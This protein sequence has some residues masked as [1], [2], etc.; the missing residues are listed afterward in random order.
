MLFF[1]MLSIL[2]GFL[3]IVFVPFYYK[4]LKNVRKVGE[5]VFVNNSLLCLILIIVHKIFKK[6]FIAIT[7]PLNNRVHIV[8]L[9]YFQEITED[10]LLYRHEYVHVLQ[11]RKYNRFIFLIKYLFYSIRYGYIKNPLEVEAYTL[12]SLSIEEIKKHF[13]K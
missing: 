13:G 4:K 8:S 9:T 5:V 6:E 3:L 2:I 11:V 12:E 7:N 10:N 1:I